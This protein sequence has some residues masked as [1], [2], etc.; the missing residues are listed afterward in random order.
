MGKTAAVEQRLTETVS[1]HET[2]VTGVENALKAMKDSGGPEIKCRDLAF[3]GASQE[4]QIESRDLVVESTTVDEIPATVPM[5][6][7]NSLSE[8]VQSMEQRLQQAIA[9]AASATASAAAV[10]AVDGK[11]ELEKQME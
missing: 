8:K 11:A 9:A 10:P 1:A 4:P 7:F 3:D 5:D 6:E 2:R